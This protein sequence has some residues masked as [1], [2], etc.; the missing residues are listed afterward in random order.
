MNPRPQFIKDGEGPNEKR[1]EMEDNYDKSTY[2]TKNPRTKLNMSFTVQTER[3][4]DKLIEKAGNF[5]Q[6][7]RSTT[8]TFYNDQKL[9]VME[10]LDR[11]VPH[12]EKQSKRFQHNSIYRKAR[13]LGPDY[14]DSLKIAAVE[15]NVKSRKNDAFVNIKK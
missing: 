13:D 6:D 4:Q 5:L 11:I 12:F 10:K 1:F 2:L 3:D 15:S 14:Y 8:D 7:L 9:N